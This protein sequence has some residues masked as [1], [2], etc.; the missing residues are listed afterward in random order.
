MDE[1]KELEATDLDKLRFLK[2]FLPTDHVE[3][4][5]KA[6]RLNGEASYHYYHFVPFCH[7]YADYLLVN[8]SVNVYEGFITAFNKLIKK[9]KTFKNIKDIQD[10]QMGVLGGLTFLNVN[11][12]HT[13][14][15]DRRPPVKN[16][17]F[18]N[19]RDLEI[20]IESELKDFF[21]DEGIYIK[22]QQKHGY[23]TSDIT[24]NG[25]VT[26]ELKKSNAKRMNV[27]QTFEYSFDEKLNDVCLLTSKFDTKTLSI[28]N[29]LGIACYTYSFMY[30]ESVN[31]YPIGF[32]IEKANLTEK[33]LFDEYLEAM[34]ECFWISFYDPLFN[35]DEAISDKKK[36]VNNIYDHTKKISEKNQKILLKELEKK[37]YDVSKGVEH[38]IKQI[39]ETQ[40]VI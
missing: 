26:I 29:R 2:A 13:F 7:A 22:R 24:I 20:L 10:A 39:K 30:E 1:L 25:K 15:Q 37:G 19:E 23:G 33:N 3:T 5:K 21:G 18:V 12:N 6:Y 16:R 32:V 8:G 31:E 27:Y 38:V 35:I 28:A 14:I 34:D 4:Y 40:G 17:E 36:T 9:D 11:Y